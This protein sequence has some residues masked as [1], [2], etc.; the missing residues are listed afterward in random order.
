MWRWVAG[1]RRWTAIP[2]HKGIEYGPTVDKSMAMPYSVNMVTW[3]RLVSD[4]S[5][6]ICKYICD[7]LAMWL[8]G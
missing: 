3:L 4:L 1:G 2:L 7:R 5:P 6:K 8:S